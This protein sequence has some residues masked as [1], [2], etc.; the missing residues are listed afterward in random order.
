MWTHLPVQWQDKTEQ[1]EF[2]MVKHSNKKGLKLDFSAFTIPP[3]ISLVA[4]SNLSQVLGSEEK[5][6]IT[7]HTA[8]K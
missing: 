8:G 2:P 1:C 5:Q 7:K 6:I 4:I 3:K